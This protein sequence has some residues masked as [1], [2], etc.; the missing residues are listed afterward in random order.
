LNQNPQLRMRRDLA[1]LPAVAL[2]AGYGCRSC[3][4]GEE[5]AWAGVLNGCGEL[6]TWDR[7]RVTQALASG[8]AP[9]RIQFV[10]ARDVPVA[11][12]CVT[13]H[14]RDE[15]TAAEIGWV[16]VLPAHQG[17]RLGAQITL[18]ACHAAR[19]LGFEEVFL[20]TDDFRLPAIKTYLNLDFQPDSWHESHPA[21][22]ARIFQALGMSAR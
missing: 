14:P 6:G 1:R 5:E 17:R 10:C 21:R 4:A 7:L 18:A 20:L 2:P 9:E 19:A 22:W 13:L 8:I 15:G 16:A 3:R 12:A 11:T